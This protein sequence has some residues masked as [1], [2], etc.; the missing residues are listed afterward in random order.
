MAIAKPQLIPRHTHQIALMIADFGADTDIG[1]FLAIGARVH[2]QRPPD[3][4]WNPH[5]KFH[6]RQP[7]LGRLLR[8]GTI[9][10]GR[11]RG[12]HRFIPP[13]PHHFG[14]A[15]PQ[16]DNHPANTAIPN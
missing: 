7:P 1:Q 12:D 13:V 9:Q 11:A 2:P 3:G 4:S 5:Q 6:A 15:A 16:T 10:A 8:H 14:K